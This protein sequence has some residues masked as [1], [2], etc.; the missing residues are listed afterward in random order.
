[1]NDDECHPE[2]IDPERDPEA[3]LGRGGVVDVEPGMRL[4]GS[5]GSSV[6]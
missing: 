4:P 6:G 1:M 3:V 2:Q 5:A